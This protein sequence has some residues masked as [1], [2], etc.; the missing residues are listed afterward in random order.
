MIRFYT[1][2][3]ALYRSTVLNGRAYVE[4]KNLRILRCTSIPYVDIVKILTLGLRH[5][6]QRHIF[7][8]IFFIF[9]NTKNV[10]EYDL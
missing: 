10:S 4:L 8:M 3:S 9:E 5:I 2:K 6:C 1:L 7:M